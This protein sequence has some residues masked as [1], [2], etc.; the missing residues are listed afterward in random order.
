MKWWASIV[1]VSLQRRPPT[2]G[3]EHRAARLEQ[4]KRSIGDN[5]PSRLLCRC[6]PPVLPRHRKETS[7]RRQRG[8]EQ[9]TTS[10]ARLQHRRPP[11]LLRAYASACNSARLAHPRR[12]TTCIRSISPPL[13]HRLHLHRRRDSS[14]GRRGGSCGKGASQCSPA[15][16][17]PRPEARLRHGSHSRQHRIRPKMYSRRSHRNS[18]HG[19]RE[20]KQRR[21]KVRPPPRTRALCADTSMPYSRAAL[22]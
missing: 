7:L 5:C 18:H 12:Q 6:R 8:N 16:H 21:V 14:I 15:Q 10:S 17:C 3:R 1:E 2:Q 13:C 11:S 4:D 20:C 19:C 9:Y 22:C